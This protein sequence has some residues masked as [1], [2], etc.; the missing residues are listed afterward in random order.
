MFKPGGSK[1]QAIDEIGRWEMA[2]ILQVFPDMPD[3][4]V[5]DQ[6]QDSTILQ[7]VRTTRPTRCDF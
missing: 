2:R 4:M 5:M 7:L 6:Q 3:A 1:V